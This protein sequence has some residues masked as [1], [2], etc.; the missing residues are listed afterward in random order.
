[1]RRVRLSISYIQEACEE[2]GFNRKEGVGDN[3]KTPVYNHGA[4]SVAE[5]V[6][7]IRG[8]QRLYK[9]LPEEFAG[10]WRRGRD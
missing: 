4:A 9:S 5:A 2:T 3:I 10:I 8:C 7:G 6:H 1:M